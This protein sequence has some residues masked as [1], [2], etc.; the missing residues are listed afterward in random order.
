MKPDKVN[1]LGKV[2][3]V[4]YVDS[5]SEV[6]LYKRES[7][8]GQT[9]Y[10]TQSIR[11]YDNGRSEEEILHT[12]LHE[13]LHVICWALKLRLNDEPNHDEL[14]LVALGLTD[15]ILR[16]EWLGANESQS[17]PAKG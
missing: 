12:L 10:W 14:D 16:N 9:D 6:D 5:P 15:V 8:W 3:S 17:Q 7:L 1:I 11:V 13:I 4:S 2:Y